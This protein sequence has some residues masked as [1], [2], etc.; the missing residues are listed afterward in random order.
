[1]TIRNLEQNDIERAQQIFDC[2]RS[3]MRSHGNQN[4]WN[5]GYPGKEILE[6][7]VLNKTGRVIEEDGI[8]HGVFA[9]FLTPDPTYSYI[10][11]GAWLNDEPYFTIHR[12]ASDGTQKGILKTAVKY[13]L[14]QSDNVRIDTHND[15]YVMQ[16]A[17]TKLGFKRCGIIYLENGDPRIAFQLLKENFNG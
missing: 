15:N 5:S 7:D 14:T 2:A 17:L 6:S 1:M 9:A 13:A 10:E 8:I 4:Q 12:I 3:F 11:D 16:N